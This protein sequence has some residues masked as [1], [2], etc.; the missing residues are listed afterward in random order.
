MA[1][2]ALEAN[3]Y[4]LVGSKE[5]SPMAQQTVFQDTEMFNGY[6]L[7]LTLPMYLEQR[8][9]PRASLGINTTQSRQSA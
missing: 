6:N 7:R 9:D 1:S 3:V 4:I 2:L 5:L 8:K